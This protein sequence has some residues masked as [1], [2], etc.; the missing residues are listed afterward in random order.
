M[1]QTLRDKRKEKQ[2][3]RIRTHSSTATRT[4]KDGIFAEK[5]RNTWLFALGTEGPVERHQDFF[6]GDADGGKVSD[7]EEPPLRW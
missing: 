1:L 3:K 5:V 6:K 4:A 7:V 2:L